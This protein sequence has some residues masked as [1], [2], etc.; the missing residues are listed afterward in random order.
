MLQAREWKD[1]PLA[2]AYSDSCGKVSL[3]W[4]YSTVVFGA[5][6]KNYISQ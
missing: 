6:H 4:G 5:A 1:V 3:F 2:F